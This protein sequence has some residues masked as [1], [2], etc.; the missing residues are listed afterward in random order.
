M[1]QLRLYQVYLAL[2]LLVVLFLWA[3]FNIRQ[4]REY[5]ESAARTATIKA[6]R[7]IERE[8]GDQQRLMRVFI[9]NHKPELLA[10]VRSP[11]DRDLYTRVLDAARDVFPSLVAITMADA[12][13]N[14]QQDD[15]SGMVGESCRADLASYAYTRLKQYK[16]H[17]D[18]VSFHY[19]MIVPWHDQK[20][21][22]LFMATYRL[23]R[24]LTMLN[25]QSNEFRDLYFRLKPER[26]GRMH[27]LGL[28]EVRADTPDTRELDIKDGSGILDQ[29]PLQHTDWRIVAMLNK[30]AAQDMRE[31]YFIRALVTFAVVVLGGFLILRHR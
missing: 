30:K 17:R 5:Q 19:D 14:V 3:E 23:D 4:N 22:Y 16:L 13:G 28:G 7:L 10:L 25:T 8:F 2:L 15:F 27:L 18:P 12:A 6:E 20:T 1:K 26:K 11:H 29:E 31:Y 24:I 21:E 9:L